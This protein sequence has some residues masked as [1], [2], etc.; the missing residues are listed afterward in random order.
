LHQ[1]HSQP[2]GPPSASSVVSQAATGGSQ[3]TP[4]F[5]A[6]LGGDAHQRGLQAAAASH[7]QQPL[8]VSHSNPLQQIPLSLHGS[9]AFG[10]SAFAVGGGV[11]GA[12]GATRPPLH[13][14]NL[15]P[16]VKPLNLV[17]VQGFGAT[18]VGKPPSARRDRPAAL[19]EAVAGGGGSEGAPCPALTTRQRS[20]A[21]GGTAA[22]MDL[23]P[24]GEVTPHQ[25]GLPPLHTGSTV[26]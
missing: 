22:M 23:A 19:G 21:S 8:L 3:I 25:A 26:S 13:A 4:R 11:G 2:A 16:A 10:A 7:H 15:G 9:A 17:G 5:S 12:Q 14:L 20:V 24:A 18:N 1:M 6:L